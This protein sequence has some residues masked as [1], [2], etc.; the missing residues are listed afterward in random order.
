MTT[1]VYSLFKSHFT[2][3]FFQCYKLQVADS[4]IQ[5]KIGLIVVPGFL[6]ILLHHSE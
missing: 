3:V 2:T 6:V 4:V 5:E 1:S